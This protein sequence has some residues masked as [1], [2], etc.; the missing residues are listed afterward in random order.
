MKWKLTAML[1]T[2]FC[3]SAIVF[4]Q[5]PYKVVFDIT[6]GS[7]DVHERVIRWS[8]GIL[9]THADAEVSIVLYG[10]SL[11]MAQPGNEATTDND[12]KSL[13]NEKRFQLSVCQMAMAKHNITKG[14]LI[15]GVQTVP[16]GV[17]EIIVKQAQGFG[18]I[19][20]TE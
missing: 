8:K 10:K 19:K 11:A 3:L 18:Y 12:I 7:K 1:I 2:F 9:E 15:K 4:G 6:S 5:Q 17:Y 14:M 16:D 20:V 13:L